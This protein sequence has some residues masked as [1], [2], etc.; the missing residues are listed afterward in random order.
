MLGGGGD[1][2]QILDALACVSHGLLPLLIHLRLLPPSLN[3][4]FLLTDHHHHHR[5]PHK[6]SSLLLRFPTPHLLSSFHLAILSPSLTLLQTLQLVLARSPSTHKWFGGFWTTLVFLV[7]VILPLDAIAVR[8]ERSTREAERLLEI[9][10]TF[11]A[12]AAK[13]D[14]G[15]RGGEEGDKDELEDHWIC[16]ICLRGS[17]DS[18]DGDAPPGKKDDDDD[19]DARGARDANLEKQI[20]TFDTRCH[21]PC[22]HSCTY[23]FSDP[24]PSG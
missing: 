19:D 24:R 18:P 2:H 15:G 1:L 20:I 22:A 12:A 10:Q 13:G 6:P 14:Q 8:R 5:H 9:G 21:L 17:G 11:A 7:A 16:S 3:G 23:F 4:N